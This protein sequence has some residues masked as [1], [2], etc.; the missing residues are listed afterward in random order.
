MADLLGLR[1]PVGAVVTA[2]HAAPRARSAGLP[3]WLRVTAVTVHMTGAIAWLGLLTAVTAVQASTVGHRDL[4]LVTPGAVAVLAALVAAT[5]ISGVVLAAGTAWGFG[6]WRWL[7]VKQFMVVVLVVG[8]TV[9]FVAGAA[10]L[11][12]RAVALGWLLGV[13]GVSMVKPGGR[14][15]RRSTPSR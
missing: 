15:G 4:I 12:V 11:A 14:V 13:I 10:S 2:A 1:V 5:V 9:V 7:V 3:R 6:R 8:G